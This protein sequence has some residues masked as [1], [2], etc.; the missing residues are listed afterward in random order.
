MLSPTCSHILE[1]Q[2]WTGLRAG[3]DSAVADSAPRMGV[4]PTSGWFLLTPAELLSWVE[5]PPRPPRP[6]PGHPCAQTLAMGPWTW[7]PPSRCG[8][9]GR[10]ARGPR[11]PS[12]GPGYSL[13]AGAMGLGAAGPHVHVHG[14]P[15]EVLPARLPARRLD[16]DGTVR[17]AEPVAG[18]HGGR[19]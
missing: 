1:C 4:W 15:V 8:A 7:R 16:G 13:G 17:G 5:A 11:R 6:H 3:Q 18:T 19:A 2:G 12:Q 9:E 14:H 10:L